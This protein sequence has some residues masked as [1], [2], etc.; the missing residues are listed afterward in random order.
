MIIL[1]DE[2]YY[3]ERRPQ[4][5]LGPV[6]NILRFIWNNEKK[7]FFDRTAREWG[8]VVIFYFFFFGV[9]G[10]IFALQ[11]HLSLLYIKDL[12]KPFFTYSGLLNV[13]NLLEDLRLLPTSLIIENPGIGYKPNIP[14]PLTSPII[15][16]SESNKNARSKRYVQALTDFLKDYTMNSSQREL[17]CS[18]GQLRPY[19]KLK[20]CFFDVKSLGT[21]GKAPYGYTIPI[22]PCVLIKFNKRL[23]WIPRYYNRSSILPHNMPNFLKRIIKKSDKAYIWLSCNGADNIDKEHIGKIEY[24]PNPGFPIEYFPFRGQK[25]YVSPVVAIKFKNLTP[26][27]LLTVQCIIWTSNVIEHT[28]YYMDFQIII[29]K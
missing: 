21:C 17:K 5:D 16:I 1:H 19:S 14:L 9:L 12:K 25:D 22:Q 2:T 4:P 20:P 3:K 10:L 28:S 6:K 24:I 29:E 18:E 7:T 23:G 15:W 11:M 13:K 26:N 8:E 27:R